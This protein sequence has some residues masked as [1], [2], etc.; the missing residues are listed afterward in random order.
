MK[1]T[2]IIFLTLIMCIM[3]VVQYKSFLFLIMQYNLA[4][5][6]EYGLYQ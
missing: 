4:N 3:N 1:E 6:S 2:V 5:I